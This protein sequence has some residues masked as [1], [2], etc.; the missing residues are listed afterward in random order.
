LRITVLKLTYPRLLK[1]C[2]CTYY[3]S[4]VF[5]VPQA[6]SPSLEHPNTRLREQITKLLITYLDYC[7]RSKIFAW[8]VSSHTS[9]VFVHHYVTV[10]DQVSHPYETANYGLVHF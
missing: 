1:H 10:R 2:V 7:P 3:L 9:S 5:Y 6:L 4:F 8:T